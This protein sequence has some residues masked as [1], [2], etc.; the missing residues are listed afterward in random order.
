MLFVLGHCRPVGWGH[1][2]QHRGHHPRERRAGA[3]DRD[4]GPSPQAQREVRSGRVG[5]RDGDSAN[6]PDFVHQVEQTPV[7]H[8]GDRERADPIEQLLVSQARLQRR[9]DVRQRL[10]L[11]QANA[12]LRL[13]HPEA[14]ALLT[15]L[16]ARRTE[17]GEELAVHL[18]TVAREAEQ[19]AD[20]AV[21]LLGGD[22]VAT[23]TL[24]LVDPRLDA[25]EERLRC[26][27]SLREREDATCRRVQE[28]D[29][30]VAHLDGG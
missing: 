5:L 26:G 6:H 11:P 20:E 21:A 15:D 10:H 22:G 4:R 18:G 7:G 13:R 29:C 1:F 14:T 2:R 24:C 8:A 17:L 27:V 23:D 3:A 28:R 12:L 16:L 25:R 9:T 30:L 19:N